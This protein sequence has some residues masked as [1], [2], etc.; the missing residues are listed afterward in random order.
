[1][2]KR[3]PQ[4]QVITVQLS[5][6][7]TTQSFNQTAAGDKKFFNLCL[8]I[9]SAWSLYGIA[10]FVPTPVFAQSAIAPDNTLGS[11]N[12]QVVTN[13]NGFPVEVITGGATRGINLFHSFREFN[14]SEGRGAYFFSPS[15][16]I[17]NI[18]ARV[19]GGSRSEI[20]GRLGI[21]GESK[22][23]LFLMNPN[24][25]IFG[26]DASLDLQGSFVATTANAIGF[27]E[28][29][30]FSATNPQAPGLL[31]VNPSALFFNQITRSEI[32]NRSPQIGIPGSL[33]L[34]GGD[35]T[36]D[37]GI[38]G[39]T[40]NRLELGAVAGTGTVDL[41]GSGNQMQLGFYEG[42]SKADIVLKNNSFAVTSGG[43]AI[44]IN[45]ENL[46][47]SEN[48]LVVSGGTSNA[49]GKSGDINIGARNISLNNQ[50]IISSANLGQGEAGKITLT[51]QD[52]ILLS[53]GSNINSS[54][55]ASTVGGVNNLPSGNIEIKTKNLVLDGNN[56]FISSSNLDRGSG[57]N[58]R[59][60]AD[61]S[62]LLNN[63]ASISS[64]SDGQGKSGNIDVNTRSLTLSNGGKIGTDSSGGGDSG[65]L[66]V[67]A[68]ESINLSGIATL[69]NPQTG[70][71][72]T[73]G[74]GLTTSAFA[75][76]SGGKLT[77]N[78][79][80]LRIRDGGYITT[81]SFQSGRG[82]D[83]T[84]NI[85][86]SMEVVG[87]S[88]SGSSTVSTSAVGS[89][90][91]GNLKIN[92]DRLSIRDGATITTLARGSGQAGEL[93]IDAKN[94]VEVIGG[95]SIISAIAFVGGAGNIKINTGSFH[96]INGGQVATSTFGRGR[97]GNLIVN[98]SNAVEV[99]GTSGNG[100]IS[101]LNTG[102]SQNSS[103]DAGDLTINTRNLLVRNGGIVV[104]ATQGA[105]KGGD[106]IVNASEK[107]EAIG[108]SPNGQTLS[109]LSS[110]TRN[111]TG[112]A[113][114]LTI[115][116]PD[117]LVR[118]GAQID[119]ST[120]GR[121]K[122]G[123]LTV[124]AANKVQLIG[125]SAD[126]RILSGLGASAQAGITGDAGSLTVKTQDLLVRDGARVFTGTLGT[127]RAGNLTVN[128]NNS[129]QLIGASLSNPNSVSGLVAASYVNSTGDAGNIVVNT[130]NLLARDGAQVF[131]GTFGAG[132]SGNLT[133]NASRQ[134]EL[135]G[136]SG[137]NI[138]PSGLIA[139]A[140]PNSTGNA[141]DMVVKTPQLIVRNGAE[142]LANAKGTGNA[143]IMTL[144]TNTI[145]LDNKASINAN[146]RSP[147]K[148]PNREQATINLNTQNL[149]LRRNSSITTEATG[150]NVIGGN[151]NI[152]TDLLI[153]LE[154]SRISANSDNSRGG[155][156]Q[157]NAQGV[158]VGTQPS[159]VSKY[160]TAT[161]G[162]GL[163]GTVNVNS[164]DNSSIQNSLTELPTNAIDTNALIANSC[165]ARVNKKQENSFI[166]TGGGALPNRPGDILMSNY[167]TDR[168][169]GVNN[170]N[171]SRPWKKGDPIIEPTGVYRLSNGQLVMS[172][173]CQN[174]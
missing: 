111:S 25:I 20:L 40:E 49:S 166:I 76:G 77:I 143:G 82:G 118:D 165:V 11:E 117:L 2:I 121:G 154:N 35:I 50:S 71:E 174:N 146:T 48:S 67:N 102:A 69:I 3:S 45:T 36:F 79:P 15:A 142:V 100:F 80:R 129:I 115:N 151:I 81:A 89:G 103:G 113:G 10:A 93:S 130:Q 172:R 24:G 96:L 110:S 17:Q 9:V 140:E 43:G 7:I 13:F 90:N 84:L 159:D 8:K 19:T 101:S 128:A 152:D 104:S 95:A 125:T 51:V 75:A 52:S 136:R 123:N 168:V 42:I 92:T 63:Y 112:D 65:D 135:I 139:S 91:S 158:F 16:D 120:Y 54:S 106:L 119:A 30:N 150:E 134:I 46:N 170:E 85:G 124:N 122:G 33:Y 39:S 171:T 138:F 28:R 162:V 157:I 55:A 98:A 5:P 18:L 37:S 144:D 116:T 126:G 21:L 1:M 23:N 127:G 147:N 72:F 57:G 169:R 105:G 6:L 70:G 73:I 167:S 145:R 156:V 29:G 94:S 66:L 133:V 87:G 137:N 14:V 83:L 99:I 131:N 78:T 32:I 22:P 58:I 4:R 160:I 38:A 108:T 31:T 62:I 163:S 164:P 86:D 88:P 132:K 97:G 155:R 173:E 114:D 74:S 64:S 68:S 149:T 34:V 59:I 109:G 107:V 41:I 44:A 12:S 47:L 61:D 60:F 53:N 148:D 26:Q 161:S 27:G 141:G 153:A 56:T